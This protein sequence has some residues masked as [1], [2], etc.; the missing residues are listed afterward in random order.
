VKK[1]HV[2]LSCITADKSAMD[3]FQ[4][5]MVPEGAAQLAGGAVSNVLYCITIHTPQFNPKTVPEE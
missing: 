2:A 1:Y 4:S 5:T 3:V